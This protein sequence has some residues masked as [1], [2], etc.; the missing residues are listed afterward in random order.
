MYRDLLEKRTCFVREEVRDCLED[1]LFGIKT[2]SG[3]KNTPRYRN[4]HEVDIFGKDNRA[5][6]ML[7]ISSLSS[8]NL[9][10][11][12]LYRNNKTKR[13]FPQLRRREV[14]KSGFYN[15]R[16]SKGKDLY[17]FCIDPDFTEMP[18][19]RKGRFMSDTSFEYAEKSIGN[20]YVGKRSVTRREEVTEIEN[21]KTESSFA[22]N[23]ST[24]LKSIQ[25]SQL[26]KETNSRYKKLTISVNSSSF[27]EA[28]FKIYSPC[29]NRI[30]PKK[31]DGFHHLP[32]CK[33]STLQETPKIKENEDLRTQDFL[34]NWL[35][36]KNG[37]F[38]SSKLKDSQK[39]IY[40]GHERIKTSRPENK[41]RSFI[42]PPFDS[43][44]PVQRNSEVDRIT[45][46][47]P[48][49]SE[50]IGYNPLSL[51]TEVTDRYNW[52]DKES[53]SSAIITKLQSQ[54][55]LRKHTKGSYD[56]GIQSKDVQSAGN[57][58][59]GELGKEKYSD[60]TTGLFTEKKAKKLILK[61]QK[62]RKDIRFQ[63]C[64]KV[65]VENTKE[66]ELNSSQAQ[67]SKK[68]DHRNLSKNKTQ[69]MQNETN[70][71]SNKPKPAKLHGIPMKNLST[72]IT[73][74]LKCKKT[75]IIHQRPSKI[76]SF[77]KSINSTFINTQAFQQ[78]KGLQSA[79]RSSQ[80][81]NKHNFHRSLLHLHSPS[82]S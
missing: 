24:E 31:F 22:S 65:L 74:T 32:P 20:L 63:S 21:R 36:R 47:S 16:S 11:L 45:P 1:K 5:L 70:Q 60:N 26:K 54:R 37:S 50:K 51:I 44:S 56:K 69:L 61:S 62:S 55:V 6:K 28:S 13:T 33:T 15:Q 4:I 9:A 72:T 23:S 77:I 52:K 53:V 73:N 29:I 17:T 25:K 68:Y 27:V 75:A 19:R 2:Q 66:P 38:E 80:A 40:L 34:I 35:K 8:I 10:K 3:I 82:D 48:R 57:S 7:K 42:L 12:L 64:S 59:K 14:A 71:L 58:W 18:F 39:K 79:S 76:Q 46:T 30:S 78:K 81:Q 43:L 49:S 67:L 41:L